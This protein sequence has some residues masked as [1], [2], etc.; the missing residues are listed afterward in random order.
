MLLRRL[1]GRRTTT[2]APT[3]RV[4]TMPLRHMATAKPSKRTVPTTT[5]SAKGKGKGGLELVG[6]YE[7]ARAAISPL[8]HQVPPTTLI[9]QAY[10]VVDVIVVDGGSCWV[11]RYM[12][13]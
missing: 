1:F 11:M 7:E 6:S 3:L 2:R 10:L 9:F 13:V 5:G 12:V 4:A 8:R